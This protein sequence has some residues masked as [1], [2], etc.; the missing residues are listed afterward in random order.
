MGDAVSPLFEAVEDAQDE[1]LLRRGPVLDDIGGV[2][3]THEHFAHLAV[4]R[5]MTTL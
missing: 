2:A 3:K 5:K 4:R 1:H